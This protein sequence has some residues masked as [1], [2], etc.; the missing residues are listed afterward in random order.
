MPCRNFE[1]VVDKQMRTLDRWVARLSV[2]A[3]VVIGGVVAV[4]CWRRR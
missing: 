1:D 3:L 2:A 4:V